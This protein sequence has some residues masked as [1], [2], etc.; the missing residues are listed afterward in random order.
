MTP[1]GYPL[2]CRTADGWF[3]VIGWEATPNG[4]Y[5]P[6]GVPMNGGGEPVALPRSEITE[7]DEVM[8]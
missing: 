8:P 1:Q 4:K 7:W 3:F 6:V 2:T 5:T